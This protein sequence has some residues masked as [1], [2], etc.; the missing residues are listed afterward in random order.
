ML[1]NGVAEQL[2]ELNVYSNVHVSLMRAT[3]NSM[4]E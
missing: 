3:N 2:T 1:K 4:T